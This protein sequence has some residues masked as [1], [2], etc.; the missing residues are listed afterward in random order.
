MTL[1]D[2]KGPD[3]ILQETFENAATAKRV[4]HVDAEGNPATIDSYE[5]FEDTEFKIETQPITLD[6]NTA[7]GRNATQTS[8]QNDGGGDLG[9]SISNDGVS[10]GDVKTV[11][12]GEVFELS[13]VS[14]DSITIS[15]TQDSSYRV[16]VI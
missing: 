14:V 10:F 11:K 6:V 3:F 5:V 8:I 2:P 16:T 9:I 13:D 7:L 1:T 4:L 12:D 15:I